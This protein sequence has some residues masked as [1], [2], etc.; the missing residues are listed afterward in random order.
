MALVFLVGPRGSGKSTVGRLLAE[1]LGWDF[2][3]ADVWLEEQAGLSIK[4][5]FAPHQLPEDGMLLVKMWGCFEGQIPL[6]AAHEMR[7][8]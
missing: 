7:S 4:E 3:D 2:A 6:R 8:G 5:I 1:R